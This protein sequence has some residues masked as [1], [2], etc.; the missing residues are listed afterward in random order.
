MRD[1]L[2]YRAA[3]TAPPPYRPPGPDD[4]NRGQQPGGPAPYATPAS[5]RWYKGGNDKATSAIILALIAPFCCGP[6]EI[7][8]LVW[9][10]QA[11]K[12]ADE[13]GGD[14]RGKAIAAIAISGTLSVIYLFVVLALISSSGS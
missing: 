4:W 10:F 9:G 1:V 7:L 8:A 2:P 13:R 5:E 6:L 14:G 11:L 12:L 3:Q